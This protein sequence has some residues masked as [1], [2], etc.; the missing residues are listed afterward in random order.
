MSDDW[1]WM[2]AADLGRGI[3]TGEIDPVALT[4]RYLRE[5]E[6][7]PLTGRIYARTTPERAMAEATEAA[8]RATLGLR[9]SPLDG[10]PIS[11]KDLFDS[12]GTATE[13]GSALLEGRVPDADARVLRNATAAG[14]VCLGKTHMSELAF[15]GLGLNPITQ[16]P[17]CVN[18]ED[19]VAGGSSSGAAASVA[20]GIAA[21][22]IGSDTGGSV[23]IPACWNDLIGLKTTSGRLSLEGLVPLCPSFDTVGP[24]CRS[25]EDAALLLAALEG[26]RAADLTGASLKGRRLMVLET[27]ALDNL[28]EAPKRGFDSALEKLAAAGA[29]LERREV[30][31]VDPMLALSP[32]L[33]APEAYGTWMDAIEA[34]PDKM[35]PM[36]LERFRGGR[37]YGGA[38][39]VHAWQELHGYRRQWQ[40]RT[41]GFDAVLVPTA[42]NIAP[43]ADRLMSDR[44]Y[45]VT[46]NLLTL[47]NTRIGNL[48]GL[49]GLTIPTG[50]PSTG[51]Q[52]MC[53]P[54]AEERLLRLG[55]AAEAALA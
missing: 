53:P 35:F 24:L 13:A 26:G 22:G 48:L 8:R 31:F 27:G 47:S 11:W 43:D 20:H 10:V 41:A 12:A 50:V 49:C 9:R 44:N 33:F 17:P 5:M 52:L 39:F 19:A 16:S 23:R 14:L 6:T 40:E 28:R 55:I 45:Y 51:I 36:I 2:K 3:E 7:H 38:D 25:V 15:S 42:P 46:E 1:L 32:V 4:E 18:D 30:A 29:V 54:N 34:A 37:D 21:A